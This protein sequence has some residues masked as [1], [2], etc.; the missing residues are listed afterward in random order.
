MEKQLKKKCFV[1]MPISKTRRC[2]KAEW[3][4]IF[5]QMIKP[6]VTGSRL[7]FDCERAKPRTG[8]FI[9]DIVN[10]LNTAHVVIADLTD[11]NPNV[12]YELGVRH[13][14]KTRT[15][16][17]AQGK[18]YVPSDL[19]AYWVIIYEKDLT[20]LEDFKRKIR[21]ILREI[22]KN[23]E[24]S[25]SPVADFLTEK[26]INLLS[27]EKKRNLAMLSALVSE[28]SFNITSVGSILDTVAKS[29]QIREKQKNRYY[30]SN[31]RFD[32]AC[33]ELLL[34]TQYI[35]LPKPLVEKVR[36]INHLA[37]LINNELDLWG[38]RDPQATE[39]I[40]KEELPFFKNDLTSLLKDMNKVKI[41][42]A[43][44]NYME[45]KMPVLLL[46]I[47]EHQKYLEVTK[48]T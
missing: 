18:K 11:M 7:G 9:K 6:A 42:Y 15:I 19:Q 33:L 21:E 46:S 48:Q 1:I 36:R 32:N 23:P 43:N 17:I 34:S 31:E 27:F 47:P 30:M 20:G 4:G 37:R 25:D 3:T 24:K 13:T 16:L 45:S 39:E 14:L 35:I 26:N 41:D 10:Q 44:D 12:F 2:T 28:L 40:L 5:E 29:E 22:E 38:G 8:N